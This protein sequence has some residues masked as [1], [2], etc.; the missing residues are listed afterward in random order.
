MAERMARGVDGTFGLL[1]RRCVE[2]HFG[3]EADGRSRKSE[4]NCDNQEQFS[5]Y[6]RVDSMI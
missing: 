5:L 6:K 4:Q 1:G 2:G 3:G